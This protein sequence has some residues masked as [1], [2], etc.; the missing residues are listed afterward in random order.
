MSPDKLEE[1]AQLLTNRD[2]ATTL[3]IAAAQALQNAA[4]EIRNPAPTAYARLALAGYET[5]RA[6]KPRHASHLMSDTA[7]AAWYEGWD[8]AEQTQP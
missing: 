1:L 4:D 5:Q 7:Q 3:D 6:G 2:Q 8:R